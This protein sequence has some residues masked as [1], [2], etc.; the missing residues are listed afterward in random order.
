MDTQSQAHILALPLGYEPVEIRD[1][2]FGVV[3]MNIIVHRES[4]EDGANGNGT[5]RCG[6]SVSM[7]QFAEMFLSS[8][9][10]ELSSAQLAPSVSVGSG[11]ART[12]GV[13]APAPA[14]SRGRGH[15]DD[16][17]VLLASS[18]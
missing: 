10:E 12:R 13:R 5:A 15:R 8:W 18:I 17:A 3:L 14:R 11:C 9:L 1:S 2:R 6:Y 16:V 7:R 4:R